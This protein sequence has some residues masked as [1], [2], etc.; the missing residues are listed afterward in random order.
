MGE[1]TDFNNSPENSEY[2]ETDPA[3]TGNGIENLAEL[4]A[5]FLP[6]VKSR[7]AVYSDN[8][9]EYE[10]FV[11]EASI[12]FLDA[13]RSFKPNKAK[14][15]AFAKLCIDRRLN[16]CLKHTLRKG[17][18]PKTAFVDSAALDNGLIEDTAS[19]PAALVID[20]DKYSDLLKC[21]KTSLSEFEYDVFEL[22]V[23]DFSYSEISARLGVTEKSVDNAVQ[24]VRMK[25]KNIV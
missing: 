11:Q 25:L 22:Y 5:D 21:I 6:L 7:A 4:Y 2:T 23:L 14:F 13:V 3:S 24:R 15:P 8:P 20:E 16:D 1:K 12:A 18:V 17:N 19:D 9:S 10:D